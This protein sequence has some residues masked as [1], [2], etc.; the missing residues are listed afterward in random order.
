MTPFWSGKIDIKGPTL[1][2]EKRFGCVTCDDC[3]VLEVQKDLSFSLVSRL[4]F[5]R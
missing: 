4:L 1:K 5:I 3:Q 2:D